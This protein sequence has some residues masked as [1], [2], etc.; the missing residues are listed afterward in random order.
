MKHRLPAVALLATLAL[1]VVGL[2]TVS[3]V[4]PAGLIL[5]QIVLRSEADLAQVEAGAIPV[6]ARLVGANG[7]YL[8]AIAPG[9]KLEALRAQGLQATALAPVTPGASY[10]LA[11]PAKGESPAALAEWAGYS[12]STGCRPWCA[13]PRLRQ[14][15]WPALLSRS[16]P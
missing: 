8:L 10:Y 5:T 3:A 13:L 11:V 1:L 15:S 7:P 14:P 16:L 6:Y 4:Q 2:T 9:H 12:S